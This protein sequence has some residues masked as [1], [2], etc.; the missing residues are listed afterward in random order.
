MN[1]IGILIYIKATYCYYIYIIY[2]LLL[3]FLLIFRASFPF[4]KNF[5]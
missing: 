5:V 2:I 1:R 4:L 3:Y